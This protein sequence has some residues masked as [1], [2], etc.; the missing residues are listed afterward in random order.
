[1]L[2]ANPELSTKLGYTDPQAQEKKTRFGITSSALVSRGFVFNTVFGLSVHDVSFNAIANL[3]YSGLV[4]GVPVFEGDLIE[5]KSEVL[6]VEFRKDG[7]KNGSVQVQTTAENQRGEQVLR[8]TRQVLVRAEKGKTYDKSSTIQKTPEK[9][10]ITD[11]VLPLPIE[12]G[13]LPKEGG[14][15]A[16]EE[17]KPGAVFEG[18]FERGITLA[19]FSWLQISTMN[20]AAV[21]HTPGSVFIGYGGAV[22]ALCEGA[23]SGDFAY[24]PQIG[25]N[26]GAH[27]APTYPCDVVETL[28]AGGKKGEHERIRTRAEVVGV[29]DVKGREDLGVVTIRLTGE[30]VVTDGGMAA[31]EAA[32]F[33]GVDAVFEDGGKRWLRVLSL[34]VV[35]GVAR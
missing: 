27:N 12:A 1:M 31:M 2:A 22:K 28:Y 13:V 23:V 26:S 20:D 18:S 16:F 19:D 33:A 4:F 11:A 35:Y 9:I 34:E 30:K 17:L 7:A 5:A 3:S 32:G 25:M 24:A 14:G 8:Y 29:E 6:G 21:H 15:V 10:D